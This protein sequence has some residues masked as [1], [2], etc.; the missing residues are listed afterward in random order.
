MVHPVKIKPVQSAVQD[1]APTTSEVAQGELAVNVHASSLAIY[2]LDASGAVAVLADGNRQADIAT[3]NAATAQATADLAVTA[4]T[5]TAPIVSTGGLTPALSITAA[6]TSAA[7][8][9]SSAD[10]V[11]LDAVST[12]YVAL[13]GSTMTGA[14]TLSGDPT[15]AMN[16]STKQYTDANDF[17]TRTGTILSPETAGD[18]VSIGGARRL[19]I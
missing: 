18:G 2:T 1:K 17:W 16:A 19:N 11:I 13:A 12:T 3:T 5:G 14:L 10:K 7:G 8:T 9:M 15:L 6:T 4:V